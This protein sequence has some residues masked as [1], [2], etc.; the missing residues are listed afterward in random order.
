[1]KKKEIISDAEIDNF[2]ANSYNIP[3][4]PDNSDFPECCGITVLCNFPQ[5][6]EI[7]DLINDLKSD[8]SDEEKWIMPTR[9]KLISRIVFGLTD[10]IKQYFN[11]RENIMI[12]LLK[13]EQ[14]IILSAIRSIVKKAPGVTTFKKMISQQTRSP[15]IFITFIGNDNIKDTV[16]KPK[17]K[18]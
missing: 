9:A 7:E 17:K 8:I 13:E 6:D 16:K 10:D 2:I 18:K 15:L 11:K 1:M 4:E 12:A 5:N 3:G 14:S